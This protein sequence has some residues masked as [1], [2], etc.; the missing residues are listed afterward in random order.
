MSPATASLFCRNRRTT[1]LRRRVPTA[2]LRSSALRAISP[3]AFICDMA[4]F[5]LCRALPGERDARIDKHVDEVDQDIDHDYKGS[6]DESHAEDH[7]VVPSRDRVI[8]EQAETRPREDLLDDHRATE[9]ARNLQP[10]D[11][12]HRDEGVAQSM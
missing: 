7:R 12:Y 5:L 10:P 8:H 2:S 1:M 4:P 9:D 11:R 6:S 3:V